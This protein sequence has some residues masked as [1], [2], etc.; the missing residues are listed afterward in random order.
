MKVI[1]RHGTKQVSLFEVVCPECNCLFECDETDLELKI[2][3]FSF[4]QMV[5][6]P[7]CEALI[8]K[9]TDSAYFKYLGKLEKDRSDFVKKQEPTCPLPE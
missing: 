1:K 5:S 8:E 4:I 2:D 3:T 7:D 6:C 9:E